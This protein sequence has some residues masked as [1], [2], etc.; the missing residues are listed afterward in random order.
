MESIKLI[1]VSICITTVVTAIFSMLVPNTKFDKI[2]KFAISLF[3]LAGL[4]SPFF[5]SKLNFHIDIEDI[6]YSD[7]NKTMEQNIKT[8]FLDLAVKNLEQSA[9]KLLKNNQ[10]DAKE[11][12]IDINITQSESIE[13]E[14]IKVLF[15]DKTDIK[16]T[17]DLV[18][19][20][21][22]IYPQI[23]YS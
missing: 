1:G 22:G 8:E 3:F 23:I 10:I 6:A 2:L 17:T 13:I 7:T 18:F 5:N 21:F 15:E 4:I 14:S 19:R 20:D 16:N 11:V 12:E 9:Y